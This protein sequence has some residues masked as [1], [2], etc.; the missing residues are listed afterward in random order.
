M[1]TA[2]LENLCRGALIERVDAELEK[3]VQNVLDPNTKAKAKR[4]ILLEMKVL[5][6]ESR[7]TATVEIVTKS[8]L[9]PATPLETT[10][11]LGMDRN[12]RVDASELVADPA[13]YD[14]DID[15]TGKCIKFKEGV[16]NA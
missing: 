3:V 7:D 6:S 12:G 8:K 11:A 5:P 1:L 15:Q 2:T 4:I 9:E 16:A 13:E 14:A 10:I